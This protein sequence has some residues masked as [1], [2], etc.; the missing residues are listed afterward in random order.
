MGDRSLAQT[1]GRKV[2]SGEG[3]CGHWKRPAHLSIVE[4]LDGFWNCKSKANIWI[5]QGYWKKRVEME[6][7]LKS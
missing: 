3:D 1:I 5:V 7:K 4:R 2:F 6:V